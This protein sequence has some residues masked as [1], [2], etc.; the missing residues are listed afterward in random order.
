MY[1]L[2]HKY[3]HTCLN[4]PGSHRLPDGV[5]IG[6][7]FAEGPQIQYVYI[8]I[9]ICIYIYIYII[10]R[11]RERDIEVRMFP[12]SASGAHLL[13]QFATGGHNFDTCCPHANQQ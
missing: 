10:D 3:I 12:D 11:E 2:N 4:L 6:G 7:A 8:Y 9:Y 5:G 13:L 1:I